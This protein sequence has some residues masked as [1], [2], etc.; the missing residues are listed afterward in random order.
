MN[1]TNQQALAYGEITHP[2]MHHAQMYRSS[3]TEWF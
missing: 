1:E 3:R 2:A